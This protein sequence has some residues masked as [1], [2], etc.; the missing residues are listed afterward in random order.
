MAGNNDFPPMNTRKPQGSQ[1]EPGG[2]LASFGVT[3]RPELLDLALTHRSW[4]YEHKA[5]P[6]NE[7][8]E[9]L[10][11]SVLGLAVTSRLYADFPALTEGQLTMRRAAIVSSNALSGIARTIGLGEHIKLG[12]GEKRS[13]GREKDSILADTVEAIIGAVYLS[14]G[15]AAA[16]RFVREL[17][18]PLF[19]NI[20][21]LVVLFDPKT[22]LQEEAV[23]RGEGFPSYT[24]EGSGPNHERLYTAKVTLGGFHGEGTGTNK[25]AAELLAARSVIEQLR[26]AGDLRTVAQHAADHSQAEPAASPQKAR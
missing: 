5:A 24:V 18:D 7:R 14:E 23:A 19:A 11:D 6:H 21:H 8:L 1:S 26:A 20:E 2:F 9:F 13:G 4:A 12:R 25:K 22:T 17:T 16:D 15:P 3:V 10:G